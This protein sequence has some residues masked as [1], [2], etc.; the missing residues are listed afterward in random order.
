[1]DF[2]V[3]AC[4]GNHCSSFIQ[5]EFTSLSRPSLSWIENGKIKS[6]PKIMIDGGKYLSRSFLGAEE[7]SDGV[8]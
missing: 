5:K 1:M 3:T 4:V 6:M 2:S 8:H 7:G